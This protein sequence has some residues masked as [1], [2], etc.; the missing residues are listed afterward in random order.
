MFGW[1]LDLTVPFSSLNPNSTH[2]IVKMNIFR[3]TGDLSHLAAILALLWKIWKSRSV[4]GKLENLGSKETIMAAGLIINKELLSKFLSPLLLHF[5]NTVVLD[6]MN[7]KLTKIKSILQLEVNVLKI[8]LI[9]FR[10]ERVF[11]SIVHV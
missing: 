3:L 2:L 9:F 5:K 10:A 4:A 8:S 6:S 1:N 7:H 11:V